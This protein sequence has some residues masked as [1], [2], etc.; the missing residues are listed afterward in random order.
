MP[1]VCL[2]KPS[3]ACP[4]DKE[5]M[6]DLAGRENELC[7]LSPRGISCN[8]SRPEVEASLCC[9]YGTYGSRVAM[10]AWFLAVDFRNSDVHVPQSTEGN[11]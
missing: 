5:S 2:P 7:C 6:D 4:F 1:R 3:Q 8:K 9:T 11:Y 10:A